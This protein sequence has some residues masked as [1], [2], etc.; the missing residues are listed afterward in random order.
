[1]E[2]GD[3]GWQFVIFL[4]PLQTEAAPYTQ[5]QSHSLL[6]VGPLGG[7]SMLFIYLF[8]ATCFFHWPK[9]GNRMLAPEARQ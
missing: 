6:V 7:C 2:S 4:N 9:P 3:V 1:M 5:P 8:F